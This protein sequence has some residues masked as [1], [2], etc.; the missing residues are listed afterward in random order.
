MLTIRIK[1]A[2]SHLSELV[3][4]LAAGGEEIVITRDDKPVAKLTASTAVPPTQ[5]SLRDLQPASVGAVLRPL[6]VD[7][8]LLNEMG[9]K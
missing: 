5:T 6:S 2:Q 9:G 3:D 1:D 8:D 7:D 4:S